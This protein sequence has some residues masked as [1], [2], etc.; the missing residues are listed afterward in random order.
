MKYP[1]QKQYQTF[2]K[3]REIIRGSRPPV[4]KRIAVPSFFTLMNLFSGFLAIIS[5]ADGDLTRGAWLIMAAG[6]F[7][8][9]D[10]MMARLANAYSDFGIELDSLSDM[11]SFGVAPG[12]LI[13]TF[14]LSDLGMLGILVS[15]LPPLCG[16][17]RLARFNV[18][19]RLQPRSDV[20]IGLPIPSVAIT[21]IAFF[22]TFRDDLS[23]FEY[24]NNGVYSVVIPLVALVSFLMVSSIQ[25][26]KIPRFDRESIRSKKLS[27]VLFI[28][29]LLL[30]ATLHEYGLMV[31]IVVYISKSIIDSAIKF[32][33]D[34]YAEEDTF[35]DFS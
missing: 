20:F 29:Y 19:A 25:F 31:A 9:F 33:N 13:Y 16:A 22:L 18:N 10:G 27:F 30:I 23:L 17:V 4:N 15:A 28:M 34:D 7:D 2:K 12:F 6:M 35:Q 24:F 5:I 8:V 32:F 11:V 21:I 3:R 26:E 14:A 1:I